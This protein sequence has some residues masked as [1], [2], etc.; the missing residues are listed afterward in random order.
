MI[1]TGQPGVES[2][3]DKVMLAE[4]EHSL[5]EAAL[6]VLGPLEH[7]AEQHVWHQLY[8]YGRAASVYGGSV[9]IQR[10]NIA[11]RILGLPRE[12]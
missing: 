12:G 11:Q 9:E 4:A 1:V 8:L 5:G 3:A 10:N 2:S 6:D 7:G